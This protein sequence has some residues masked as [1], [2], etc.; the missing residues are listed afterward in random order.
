M[1]IEILYPDMADLYG[2]QGSFMILKQ[3]FPDCE[4]V[5]TRFQSRPLFADEKVDI[6][7]LG[8]S[9]E[10][11]QAM[12]IEQLM[13][14]K[15]A[16][17]TRIEEGCYALFIGNA[18]EVLGQ[19]VEDD[20]GKRQAALGLYDFHAK[21]EFRTRLNTEYMGEAQ[22]QWAHEKPILGF[23]TQFSVC[24]GA[25]EN[26]A[27][28]KNLR[29]I[30]MDREASFEGF[31]DHNLVATYLVGPFLAMNPYFLRTWLDHMGEKDREIP[32]YDVMIEAYT[33]RLADFSNPKTYLS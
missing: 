29:G 7:Y 1:K 33:R 23:K 5:E 18:L 14:Y 2:E 3:T 20:K 24:H 28:A 15:E 4:I 13:P 26:K 21:Q 9:S 10:K 6:L 8:P 30:G 22:Q 16:L 25:D 32:F 31:C 19:Y 11:R 17:R 12:I 27:L